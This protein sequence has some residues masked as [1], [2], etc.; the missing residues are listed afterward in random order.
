MLQLDYDLA[1]ADLMEDMKLRKGLKMA[2][3]LLQL[4]ASIQNS[5]NEAGEKP[6]GEAPREESQQARK[7]AAE[8]AKKAEQ[9]EKQDA[10][11][12]AAFIAERKKELARR[13]AAL[14][15][16]QLDLEDAERT[17]RETSR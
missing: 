15:E 16:R 7:K 13:M 4:G 14:A 12:E 1:R 17:Y 6:P 11:E 2:G 3:G 8:D 5:I 9:M 10:A